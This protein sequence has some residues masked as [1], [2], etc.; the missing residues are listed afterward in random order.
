MISIS[1]VITLATSLL[2]KPEYNN[3]CILMFGDTLLAILWYFAKSI[4][5]KFPAITG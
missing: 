2:L 1:P 4:V 3:A 5:R